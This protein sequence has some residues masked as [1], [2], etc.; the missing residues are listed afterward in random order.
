MQFPQP[1]Y[2][3]EVRII[4]L[5]A[6]VQADFPGGVRLGATNPS[7]FNIEL[8]VNDLSK[9]GASAFERLGDFQYNQNDCINYD[10]KTSNTSTGDRTRQIPTDGLV[11]RG[12]YT[13]ITLA[14]YG[15]L[16]KDEI[17]EQPIISPPPPIVPIEEISNSLANDEK[18]EAAHI[19]SAIDFSTTTDTKDIAQKYFTNETNPEPIIP[20]SVSISETARQYTE[21]WVASTGPSSV[22][23]K[24]PDIDNWDA[25]DDLNKTT[26][27]ISSPRSGRRSRSPDARRLKR[28]WSKSPDYRRHRPYERGVLDKKLL[29]TREYEASR[30]S[31]PSVR[32]PR[33]PSPEHIQ[34]PS[35][36]R[37]P[38]TPESH[39]SDDYHKYTKTVHSPQSVAE[40]IDNDK[41]TTAVGSIPP[42]EPDDDAMSQG[43]LIEFLHRTK[44]IFYIPHYFSGEQFEPILSDD[45]IPDDVIDQYD[46]EYDETENSIDSALKQFN[47]FTEEVKNYVPADEKMSANARELVELAAKCLHRSKLKESASIERTFV[48]S[49][50][51]EMR[52]NWVHAAEQLIQIINLVYNLAGA[53][54]SRS[55]QTLNSLVKLNRQQLVDWMRIGLNFDCANSQQQPGY[56]I[57]HM[58][59]GLRLIEMLAVDETFIE[60]LIFKE[61]FNVFEYLYRLYEQK[62]MALSL[63]LM[64]CRAIFAC[65]D[66]KTGIDF[67]TRLNDRNDNDDVKPISVENG[68]QKLIK[69]LQE[70]P[71]TRLKFP[72]KSILKKVNLY[73]SLHVIR[74]IVNRRF[75]SNDIKIESDENELASDEQLLRNCLKEVWSAFT[76]D[77]QSYS[78]PKRFLPISTKFE[79]VRDVNANKMAANS[80]IRYFRINGLIESLLMI[81]SQSANHDIVSEQ[82]F[83]LTLLILESLCRTECG[84]NYLSEKSDVTNVLIKCLIQ[85]PLE[86]LN[87]SNQVDDVEMNDIDA[88]ANQT[89]DISTDINDDSRRYHLG[90]E[91]AYKVSEKI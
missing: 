6:R 88:G 28:D 34:S 65:L 78:Q 89:L 56:K 51:N 71:L 25:D 17:S 63:K 87:Q 50:S 35:E 29:K 91:I 39:L 53:T 43:K 86:N 62:F 26:T 2:I 36:S 45:E 27:T 72:L 74:D 41:A 79:K 68:Y 66:T 4:P 77:S 42:N 13:T 20:S 90:I 46:M 60:S 81:V 70:N 14:V 57:R 54:Q 30:R 58:K 37:R 3:G 48:E 64:I 80:F 75:V 18:P 1:V 19:S 47:P 67:F 21:D 24:S 32:A 76:W 7:K 44:H 15:S 85:A 33:T 69:L 59:C 83:D 52:E 22:D 84:L 5:G 10:A 9:P 31:P 55:Q 40:E 8:F 38:R 49:Q 16:A 23:A 12:S 82:V 61:K 73:E 11:L